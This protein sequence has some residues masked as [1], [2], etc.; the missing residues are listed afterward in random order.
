MLFFTMH[1]MK[2]N[3]NNLE[4]SKCVTRGIELQFCFVKNSLYID[5]LA[6]RFGFTSA[7]HIHAGTYHA[8]L[9]GMRCIN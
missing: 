6:T 2:F 5:T 8:A 4:K 1:G 3:S 9:K 7:G